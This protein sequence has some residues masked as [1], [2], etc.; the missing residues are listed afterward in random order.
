MKRARIILYP[1]YFILLTPD[2][3]LLN[4]VFNLAFTAIRGVA[5]VI[6]I[7]LLFC[8]FY[9]KRLSKMLFMISAY[10]LYMGLNTLARGFSISNIIRFIAI[11]ADIF[12]IAVFTEYLLCEDTNYF[13]RFLYK[14][15]WL[16]LILNTISVFAFPNGLVRAPNEVGGSYS[17]YFYGY[18]NRF[19]VRYIPSFAIIFIYEKYLL[20][21]KRIGG[22]GVVAIVVCF[23][24][25]LYL[26]STASFIAMGI[27]LLGYFFLN[28]IPSKIIN[29]RSIWI[30]Y[31]VVDLVLLLGSTVESWMNVVYLLN[32]A[33]SLLLRTKMWH[34]AL[35]VIEDNI[36]FGI[37][38]KNTSFM[39]DN[40][41]FAQLH[42]SFLTTLLW[43]GIIGIILYT[44][45]IFTIQKGFTI[46]KLDQK[47]DLKFFSILF[48]ALMVASLFDGLE[49]TA[50]TYIYYM[51]VGN[52][53]YVEN[54]NRL[55]C[56][57]F[58]FRLKSKKRAKV[59]GT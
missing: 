20:G 33:E 1:L 4:R 56:R 32:K 31:I 45:F 8:L 18:D 47:I 39:R 6:A 30:G 59:R 13:I 46:R 55:S 48:I 25:L 28:M 22:G 26:K 17:A 57:R 40:F 38:V 11:Y 34:A 29:F 14:I 10:I 35:N 44:I 37:G 19:I 51:I 21:K 53:K 52:Y 42:N 27:I 15:T 24:T 23:L 12:V 2:V 36:I 50:Y 49:L 3:F 7:F 54:L 43:G 41:L 58:V 9:N 16:G 5:G